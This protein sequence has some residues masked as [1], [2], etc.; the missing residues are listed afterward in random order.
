[1]SPSK[2][3]LC[4]F[5]YLEKKREILIKK[6]IF[7]WLWQSSR[8]NFVKEYNCILSPIQIL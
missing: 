6:K 5:S 4:G 3:Y 8:N 7:L 2:M 1:M